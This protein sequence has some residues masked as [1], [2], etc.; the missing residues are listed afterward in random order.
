[1]ASV[2]R[3]EKD[4]SGRKHAGFPYLSSIVIL[5]ASAVLQHKH[6]VT[7]LMHWQMAEHTDSI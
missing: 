5:T 7:G 6:W 4:N 2:C 1:M 3:Q